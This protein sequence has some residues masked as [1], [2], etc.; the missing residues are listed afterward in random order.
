[1]GVCPLCA[2]LTQVATLGIKARNAKSD[3]KKHNFEFKTFSGDSM[4][5]LGQET[6]KQTAGG[7][8]GFA[9]IRL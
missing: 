9:I 3:N 2:N 8:N 6:L 1:M 4:N 5:G 7:L